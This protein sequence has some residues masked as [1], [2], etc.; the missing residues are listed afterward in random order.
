MKKWIIAFAVALVV[1]ASVISNADAVSIK[2]GSTEVKN[3]VIF[4]N[5][6]TYVPI[7]AVSDLLYP[8]ANVTWTNGQA[9][10]TTPL[11]TITARPGDQYIQ[12]NGRYLYA[13]EGVRLIN[14]RTLVPVRALAKAFGASVS[15]NNA[16]QKA[17]VTKGSGTI[18]SG[19]QYYNSDD[20]Y[21]LS[22][23]INSES[24]GEP[25]LGKIAVGD[26][27]LNRVASPDYPNS[28]YDVIFDTKWGVQFEP[29]KN[30]SIYQTPSSDSVI[31]AKLCLD[32]ASVVGNCQYFFN[33]ATASS[34]WIAKNSTY[35][36]T[37]G[38]HAFY[39]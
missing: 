33:P 35:Y 38:N 21:W 12:A 29:T 16:A 25:M 5:S 8:G 13:V 7:R 4:I 31:A 19:N 2:V 37:I 27:I 26:V 1:T 11:V 23:I 22:R 10:V 34:S 3:D 6:T 9:V 14:N 28:I 15:W 18:L 36:C 20:V 30:G 24:S 39:A 17:T 32:G